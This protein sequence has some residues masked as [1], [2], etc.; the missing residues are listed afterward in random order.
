MGMP[1]QR[2]LWNRSL[3][4]DLWKIRLKRNSQLFRGQSKEASEVAD[5]FLFGQFLNGRVVI[6]SLLISLHNLGISWPACF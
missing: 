4:V 3:F 2:I 6:R 5:S 1:C